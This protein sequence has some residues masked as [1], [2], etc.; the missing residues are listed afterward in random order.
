[1][2]IIA[3]F[4]QPWGWSKL[5]TARKC[6]AQFAYQYIKKLPSPGNA[7]MARGNEVHETIEAYMQGWIADLPEFLAQWKEAFDEL[8]KGKFTAEQAIGI[9][10]EWTVLPDWFDKRTW[11]RAKMDAKIIEGDLL[12]VIDWKTGQYRIP[13]PDQVELY[14]IVG[15][16]LHPEV[17][18]VRAEFWFIDQSDTYTRDYEA[19]ELKI[20]RKK[21]EDEAGALYA[22][23]VW[24]ESPSRDCKWCAY[25]KSK[26]G[27]CK[28]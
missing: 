19:A 22:T 5:D 13:S 1:M 26:G 11:L 4:D 21:Y 6:K 17:T 10:K 8:K 9:S 3:T 15:H 7:A 23:Q 20:L 16:A 18:K 28:F 12:R 25:S 24:S 27:E 2:S 14:A